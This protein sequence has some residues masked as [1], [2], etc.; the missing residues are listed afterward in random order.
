[1][2][3]KYRGDLSGPDEGGSM[4]RKVNSPPRPTSGSGASGGARRHGG[5]RAWQSGSTRWPWADTSLGGFPVGDRRGS[6]IEQGVP[7]NI[8]VNAFQVILCNSLK[9]SKL[10]LSQKYRLR[11]PA[12][13]LE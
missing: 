1:M 13:S 2:L 11:H 5:G 3:C 12:G 7:A 10:Y 4:V 8:Q 9:A 6:Q